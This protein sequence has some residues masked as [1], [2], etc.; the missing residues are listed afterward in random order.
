M[1]CCV[2]KKCGEPPGAADGRKA[3]EAR[4]LPPP[5][6]EKVKEV[7]SET[8]R[9]KPRSRA[10]RVAGGTVV[11]PSA[12]KARA[13]DGH[14]VGGRVSRPARSVEE[15]SEAASESSAATTVAGPE[16]SPSKPPRCRQ[17][18]AAPGGELRR[19]R[20]DRD[21][22]AATPGGRGRASQ[23][24]P[25]PRR[26]PGRRSP[27]P[28]AKRAQDQ[29]RD[30]AGSASCAQRKPPVP[31]RPCGRTP[32]PPRGQEVPPQPSPAPPAAA[33]PL[34]HG[35]PTQCA[36]PPTPQVPEQEDTDT[37]PGSDG[38]AAAGGGE[39]EGKESLENPLVSMECFIFL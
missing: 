28:A 21:H 11:A 36:S 19:A 26:D 14:G 13:K 9:V 17:G 7:L 33:K 35:P 29:R 25:P 23:S 39:G 10:R 6:E 8:P 27:S 32:T 2:S 24:P 4:D 37:P 34:P 15:K 31:A 16:R 5:E 38:D 20:R 22:G 30:T 1:G 12:E 3:V 18:R